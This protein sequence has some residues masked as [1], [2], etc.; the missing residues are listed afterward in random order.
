MKREDRSSTAYVKINF[1]KCN[2]CWKCIEVCPQ[3]VIGI[4][5]FL[6]RKNAV[7]VNPQACIGCNKCIQVCDFNAISEL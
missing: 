7:I 2:S 1:R 4:T 5:S 6:W 3:Q